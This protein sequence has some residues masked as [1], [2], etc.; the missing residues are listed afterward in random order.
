MLKYLEADLDERGFFRSAPQRPTL[1]RNIRNFFFRAAPTVQ[2]VRTLHGIFV[3]L[4]GKRRG[5]DGENQGYIL[6]LPYV[7]GHMIGFR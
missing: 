7:N 4:R 3:S 1:L 6:Y 2:E 5:N